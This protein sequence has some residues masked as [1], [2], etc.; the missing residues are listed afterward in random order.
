MPKRQLIKFTSFILA[1]AFVS[2]PLRIQANELSFDNVYHFLS[3]LSAE[4]NII[5]DA[6]EFSQFRDK[7]YGYGELAIA[8]GMA[9]ESGH[10][11]S[12][13]MYLREQEK[14]GWGKV[15]KTIG[16]K[17]S[18]VLHRAKS[19]CQNSRMDKDSDD[20]QI[21]ITAHE[22]GDDDNNNAGHGNNAGRINHGKPQNKH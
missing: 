21:I 5:I 1:L 18:D 22:S 3:N 6:Q 13:I 7:N 9:A 11:V 16:V 20:I 12:Y 14:M 2:L 8:Y 10:P 15:G 19:V 4:F 17:V